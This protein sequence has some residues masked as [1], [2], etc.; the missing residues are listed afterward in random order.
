MTSVIVLTK[1]LKSMLTIFKPNIQTS[2]CSSSSHIIF[3][4]TVP[5]RSPGKRIDQDDQY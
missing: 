5:K 3:P 1:T 4:V 2:Q